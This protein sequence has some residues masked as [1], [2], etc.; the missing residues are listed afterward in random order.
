MIWLSRR[1]SRPDGSFA[2]V[3]AINIA[4]EQFISFYRDVSLGRRDVITV[5]GLDGIVRARLREGQFQ[6]GGSVAGTAMLRHQL[7]NPNGTFLSRSPQDGEWRYFSHRRLRD[8]PLFVTYGVLE[9]EVLAALAP[10]R[11]HL[12]RGRWPGQPAC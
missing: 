12:L 7:E 2:G 1:L 6:S 11:D 10:A 5:T 3:I 8:Y 9:A 4:P